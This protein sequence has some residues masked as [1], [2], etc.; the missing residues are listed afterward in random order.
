[1]KAAAREDTAVVAKEV[2][3]AAVRVAMEVVVKVDMAAVVVDIRLLPA[4]QKHL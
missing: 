2:M 3:E 4:R 1:M